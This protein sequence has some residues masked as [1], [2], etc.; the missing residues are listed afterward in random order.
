MDSRAFQHGIN[1]AQ[2]ADDQWLL[3]WSSSGN[4]PA[5]K[6]RKGNW[7]HDVYYSLIDTQKLVIHPNRL[8]S[9]LEAQEPASSAITEDG[10][11][12]I[13]M[14]DGWNTEQNVAQRYAV[15]DSAMKPIKAYPQ[16]VQDG[17]HSGHVAAVNQRFIV[18][19]SD[20][21]VHG[22]GVD[23]LGSGDDVLAKVY[24][25]RGELEKTVPVAVG[26]KNRDWWPLVAGSNRTAMLVWQRFVVGKTWSVL[27]MAILDPETGQLQQKPIKIASHVKYYTYSVA[28]L[29]QL[30]RFLVTGTHKNGKGFA[31]MYSQTGKPVASLEKLPPVMRE[32]QIIQ[33]QGGG[34]T[35]VVQ[36][37]EPAGIMVLSVT[38]DS[39]ALQE[40]VEGT[41][42]WSTVGT[43]GIFIDDNRL[44][45]VGL[46]Q[47]GLQQQLFEINLAAKKN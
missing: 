23:N 24:S 19:Y 45:L 47:N 43:D 34:Q 28:Y 18:F 38:A 5:G 35:T 44:F 36:A 4:P 1:F 31:H 46:S 42:K 22:G 30:K 26:D 21:W 9:K 25:S 41:Q 29:P 16:L 3:V 17:G 7:T 6:N 33:R 14:E 10:N 2:R 40:T 11:L 13:T 37:I 32:A 8:I 20:E 12:M 39:I 15:Y 27:M